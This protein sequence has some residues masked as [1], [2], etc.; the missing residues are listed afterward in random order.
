LTCTEYFIQNNASNPVTIYYYSCQ[1]PGLIVSLSLDI[2]E[3]AIIC[4]CDSFGSPYHDLGED[5]IISI[6]GPC[7]IPSQ[8]PTNT[9]TNTETPTP[10]PTN[11]PTL[12]SGEFL[13]QENLFY[14]LQEDL[15][16]IQI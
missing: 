4:N 11:T 13:Q 15:S 14:I 5:I 12:V 6:V 2:F 16:K 10:T 1:P 9:P 8:T 3:T 7:E